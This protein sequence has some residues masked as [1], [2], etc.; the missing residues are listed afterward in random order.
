MRAGTASAISIAFSGVA[1][2]LAASAVWFAPDAMPSVVTLSTIAAVSAAGSLGAVLMGR[3]QPPSTSS[4]ISLIYQTRATAQAALVHLSDM[5]ETRTNLGRE[6]FEEIPVPTAFDV[7]PQQYTRWSDAPWR[8]ELKEDLDRE[9]KD[10]AHLIKLRAQVD[11]S[12]GVSA[13]I[14]DDLVM[15]LQQLGDQQGAEHVLKQANA[16]LLPAWPAQG[17]GG[18]SGDDINSHPG[19]GG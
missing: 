5:R 4:N 13:S 16:L 18:A 15:A 14:I 12:V 7:L 10:Y 17:I 9:L 3:R 2:V 11:Q 6:L 1:L 19:G 8:D